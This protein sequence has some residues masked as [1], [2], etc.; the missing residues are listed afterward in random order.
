MRFI[1]YFESGRTK[2]HASVEA[3]SESD[4]RWA[5]E[6]YAYELSRRERKRAP[7][8]VT[9]VH[10]DKPAVEHHEDGSVWARDFDLSRDDELI[11]IA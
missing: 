11:R 5:T 2:L 1:G 8:R 4:A 6:Q 10:E 9:T 7:Y 3:A